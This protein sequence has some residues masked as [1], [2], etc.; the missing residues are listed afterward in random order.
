MILWIAL[1]CKKVMNI[2]LDMDQTLIDGRLPGEN[3]SLKTGV[4]NRPYLYDFL[5]FCFLNFEK[6]SI[7]TAASDK[8]FQ[9]VN[10]EVFNPIIQ[11]LN[12]ETEQNFAFDF[13]FT[14]DRCTHTWRHSEWHGH[15]IRVRLKRLRKLFRSKDKYK[16]YTKHN[17][18]VLDD[19][20]RTFQDNYGNSIEIDDWQEYEHEDKQLLLLINYLQNIIFP[21]YRKHLTIRNLDKRHWITHRRQPLELNKT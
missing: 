2:I 11:K 20:P 21:H 19:D 17:T 3:I 9:H 1:Y 4:F 16:D 12:D 10:R 18:L 14:R 15:H 8:W 5:K 13:V 7:W 6:V